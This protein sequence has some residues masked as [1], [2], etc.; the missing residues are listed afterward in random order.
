M[1]GGQMVLEAV[2]NSQD[3][4]A[5]GNLR[6]LSMAQATPRVFWNVVRHGAVGPTVNFQQVRSRSS[7]P[8]SQQPPAAVAAAVAAASQ[9]QPEP[10][11]AS[12]Q[13]Q[14]PFACS[15]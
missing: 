13:K 10:A 7:Q 15:Q 11:R 5:R 2:L 14:Q 4:Q 8:V 1:D 9:S 12:Q 6:P 3:A